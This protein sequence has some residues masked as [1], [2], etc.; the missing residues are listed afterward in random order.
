MRSLLTYLCAAA[1]WCGTTHAAPLTIDR[2]YIAM[3]TWEGHRLVPYKDR[4]GWSVG[5]GHALTMHGEPVR[6]A[7]TRAEVYQLFLHDF[8][9]S[10]EVC[11][12]GV[13]DFDGLPEEVQLVALSVAW[14][15]GPTGFMAFRDFRRALSRRAWTASATALYLS[16]W[17][18]QVSP[19]RA[20]AAIATLRA[21]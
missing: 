12:A 11:R 6:R 3:V 10:Q 1:L 7:Y 8:A 19:A 5:V 16:R 20:N 13:R 18:G 14:T 15:C 9:V 2:A 4:D 21:Q 17:Y